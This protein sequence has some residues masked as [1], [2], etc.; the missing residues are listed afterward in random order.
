MGFTNSKVDPNL[1]IKVMDDEPDILLLYVDD[2]F[3]TGNE[4]QITN[5]KKRLTKELKMK[6]LGLMHYFRWARSVEELRRNL[7][8]PGKVCCGNLKEDLICWI[9]NPWPHPWIP[10]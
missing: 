1:Y 4:K 5:C 6:D 10:T 7:S 3:L 9:L 2:L 8:E